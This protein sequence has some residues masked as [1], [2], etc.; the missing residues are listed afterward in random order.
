MIRGCLKSNKTK[1]QLTSN[2]WLSS[3]VEAKKQ[4]SNRLEEDLQLLIKFETDYL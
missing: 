2:L 4:L 3:G 1:G